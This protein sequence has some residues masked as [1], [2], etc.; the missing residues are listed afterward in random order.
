MECSFFIPLFTDFNLHYKVSV[1]IKWKISIS[2]FQP[3]KSSS[4][5]KI[6]ISFPFR[7]LKRLLLLHFS[8]WFPFHMSRNVKNPIELSFGILKLFLSFFTRFFSFPQPVNAIQRVCG[9]LF[10]IISVSHKFAW[11]LQGKAFNSRVFQISPNEL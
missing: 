10:G 4:S 5:K 8:T 2:C 11:S 6:L 3:K 1:D 7:K 9:F